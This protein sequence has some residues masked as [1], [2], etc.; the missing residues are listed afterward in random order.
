MMSNAAEDGRQLV[1]GYLPVQV[2]PTSIIVIKWPQAEGESFSLAKRLSKRRRERY[3][4]KKKNARW[5][6]RLLRKA[7]N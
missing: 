6:A 7:Q 5:A 3:V 1:K 2:D 4:G